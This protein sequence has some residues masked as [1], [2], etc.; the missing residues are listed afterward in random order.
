MCLRAEGRHSQYPVFI[1]RQHQPLCA[2]FR[3]LFKQ[4]QSN[5]E[6]NSMNTKYVYLWHILHFTPSHN[7]QFSWKHQHGTELEVLLWATPVIHVKIPFLYFCK[8]DV[9]ISVPSLTPPSSY[10]SYTHFVIIKMPHAVIQLLCLQD[11]GIPRYTR[12]HFTRFRYNA[13]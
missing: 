12:S 5:T 8:Y 3:Y 2:R 1:F 10:T 6:E 7:L 11:T 4:W 13:I 9:L